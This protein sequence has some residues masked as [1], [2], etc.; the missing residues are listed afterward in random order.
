L[1]AHDSSY[2]AE[3][4]WGD[5]SHFASDG[6]EQATFAEVHEYKVT[7]AGNRPANLMIDHIYD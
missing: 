7:V 4:P 2:V 6:V 5:I 1:E 3:A